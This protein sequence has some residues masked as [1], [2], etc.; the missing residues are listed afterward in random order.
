MAS[1][2]EI[3]L[4]DTLPFPIKVHSLP[5]R[6]GASVKPGHR[7]LTYSFLHIPPGNVKE[8]ETRYGSW[9]ATFDG[10]IKSWNVKIG[11]MITRQRARDKAMLNIIEPCKHG[12]QFNGLCALCGMDMD[13]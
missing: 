7:L 5:A 9:D 13:K 6:A 8:S 2:T 1:P 4:P 12:I 3:F 11:D 10:E